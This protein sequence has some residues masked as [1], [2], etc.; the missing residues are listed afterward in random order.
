MGVFIFVRGFQGR[1]QPAPPFAPLIF[2]PWECSTK[3][4]MDFRVAE[5][6]DQIV[7]W[8]MSFANGLVY[9][10]TY[11]KMFRSTWEAEQGMKICRKRRTKFSTL[12]PIQVHKKLDL[13]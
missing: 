4:P 3:A 10:C 1:D 7:S 8:K 12:L 2:K 6:I 13:Y 11:T 9:I 5:K